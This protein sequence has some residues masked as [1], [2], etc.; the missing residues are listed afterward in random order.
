MFRITVA[1]ALLALAAAGCGSGSSSDD[2]VASATGGG[3]SPTAS[4]SPGATDPDQ[5][6]KFS[7]CMRDNGIPDFPDPDANGQIPRDGFDRDS[8]SG[9]SWQKAFEA[10]RSVAPNGGER[11]ELDAAQQEQL[12]VWAQCMRDNGVDIPDPDANGGGFMFGGDSQIDPDDPKFR[13]AMD[14]CQDKF[15]FRGPGGGA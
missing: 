12:R 8:M 4:A 11:P 5:S 1:A 15:T 13:A 10:C 9:D 7:Q 2:E 6:R 3:A 14:A